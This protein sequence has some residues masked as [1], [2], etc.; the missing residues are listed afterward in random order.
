MKWR[1]M[2][3]KCSQQDCNE[4]A[5]CQY[6]HSGQLMFGCEAHWEWFCNIMEA[7]GTPIP[8]KYPIGTTIS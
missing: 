8:T 7:M 4:D 1:L 5:T 6:D 2:M 3:N